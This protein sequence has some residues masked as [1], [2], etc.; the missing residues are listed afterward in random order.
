MF[1]SIRLG[2]NSHLTD[3]EKEMIYAFVGDYLKKNKIIQWNEWKILQ[4]KILNDS[5][6]FSPDDLRNVWHSK[7]I[8]LVREARAE[9]HDDVV[10][11]NLFDNNNSTTPK[12]IFSYFLA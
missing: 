9:V 1:I 10:N 7:Q 11:F 12:N 2:N 4:S 3:E 5:H 6:K 8:Q